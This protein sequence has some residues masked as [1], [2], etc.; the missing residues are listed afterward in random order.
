MASL[1]KYSDIVLATPPIGLL[2]KIAS[3]DDSGFV[4]QLV[5]RAILWEKKVSC[6]LDYMTPK[7]KRST[8]FEV[9]CDALDAL[10]EMGVEVVSVAAG[11]QKETDVLALVTEADVLETYKNTGSSIRILPGA[12][13]TPLAR[14]KAKELHI[15]IVKAQGV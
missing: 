11:T 9:V 3:A 10:K 5:M 6:V 7:F 1:S 14:D 8:V 12:V 2:K 15:S 13:V 4:E